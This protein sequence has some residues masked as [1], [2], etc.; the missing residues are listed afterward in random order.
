MFKLLYI[1][2][3]ILSLGIGV[4]IVVVEVRDYAR[5]IR[6][7]WEDSE[8]WALNSVIVLGVVLV[9]AAIP[10]INILLPIALVVYAGIIAYIKKERGDVE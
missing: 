8:D 9:I 3:A 4:A 1:L 2:G 6:E 7:S 5:G 10:V